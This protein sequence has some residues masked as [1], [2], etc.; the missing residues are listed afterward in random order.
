MDKSTLEAVYHKGNTSSPRLFELMLK[1]RTLSLEV[2][3]NVHL[4]H[5]AGTRMITQ[6]TD[7]LSRGELQPGTLMDASTQVVPL[8]LDPITRSDGDLTAWIYEWTG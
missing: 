7:G 5:I 3:F 2:G 1:L 4:I 6:G 8:H